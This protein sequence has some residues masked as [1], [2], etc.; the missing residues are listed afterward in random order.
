MGIVDKA[1]NAAEDAIGKAKE[2]VGDATNNKDL[3]AEGKKDQGSAGVKKVGEN[4]KDT[5][6]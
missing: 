1:K 3:E 4:V 5:F 2:V 6:K